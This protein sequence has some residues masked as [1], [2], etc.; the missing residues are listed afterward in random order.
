MKKK[1]LSISYSWI[2]SMNI[3]PFL[4]HRN[5]NTFKFM[6]KWF[7]VSFGLRRCKISL[8]TKMLP[9]HISLAQK[10]VAGS[11]LVTLIKHSICGVKSLQ[12]TK[13][14]HKL[15][16]EDQF[17][18]MSLFFCIEY[19]SS[20]TDVGIFFLFYW[21]PRPQWLLVW[22]QTCLRGVLQVRYLTK[23]LTLLRRLTLE[24]VQNYN[25]H[26]ELMLGCW[27]YWGPNI[28]SNLAYKE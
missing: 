12:E 24:S 13:N 26:V 3:E 28:A 4:F 11:V 23:N 18:S 21:E 5:S 27:S 1:N 9:M 22:S 2:G 16:K 17:H 10:G 14:N 25:Y 7:L 15:T 19:F 6:V 20:L 8:K